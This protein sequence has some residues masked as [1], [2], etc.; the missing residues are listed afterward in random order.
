VPR[1][2]LTNTLCGCEPLFGSLN[3][4]RMLSLQAPPVCAGGV[5]AK[6]VPL[7][8]GKPPDAVVP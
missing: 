8:G 6:T 1:E 3:E 7:E 4:Y 2:S 5:K